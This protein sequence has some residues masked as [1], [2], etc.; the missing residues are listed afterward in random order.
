MFT[1]TVRKESIEKQK[2]HWYFLPG[3]YLLSLW[4]FPITPKHNTMKCVNPIPVKT[5]YGKFLHINTMKK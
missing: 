4:T 1:Y 5:Q 3:H 2:M